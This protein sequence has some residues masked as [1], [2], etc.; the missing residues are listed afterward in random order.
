MIVYLNLNV[1]RKLNYLDE[2]QKRLMLVRTLT[3]IL[4]VIQMYKK[5]FF[6]KIQPTGLSKIKL[7]SVCLF[8]KKEKLIR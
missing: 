5:I 1:Q 4:L 2:N 7:W 6:N 3:L 8:V